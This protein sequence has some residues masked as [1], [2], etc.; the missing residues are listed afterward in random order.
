MLQGCKKGFFIFTLAAVSLLIFITLGCQPTPGGVAPGEEATVEEV[1]PE[2][3]TSAEATVTVEGFAFNPAEVRIQAGGTVTWQ[4]KDSAPH[5]V[6]SDN[7]QFD[8]G[9]LSQGDNWSFT[10]EKPGTYEYHCE[11]HPG[12]K[13]KVIVD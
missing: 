2:E 11:I 6:T 9:S 8:S 12:M 4:Q 13:A 1:T 7:G 3:A 10:F 5:T